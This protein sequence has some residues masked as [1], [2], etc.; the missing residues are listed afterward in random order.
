[1][2]D[3]IKNSGVRGVYTWSINNYFRSDYFK[4][5]NPV[6][7]GCDWNLRLAAT[8]GWS[9]PAPKAAN[10]LMCQKY[11]GPRPAACPSAS[12]TTYG[13]SGITAPTTT[14]STGFPRKIIGGYICGADNID[15][16]SVVASGFNYVLVSF[17]DTVVSNGQFS[18]Q[19]NRCC[20]ATDVYDIAKALIAKG[21]KVSVSVGGEGC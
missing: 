4:L 5:G 14:S 18:L 2:A 6:T 13:A 15:V 9:A 8:L 1:M 11:T 3:I 12:A 20:G 16:D 10:S 7:S 21:V 19:P 17:F